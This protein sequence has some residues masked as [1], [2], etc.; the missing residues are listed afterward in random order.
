MAGTN[1]GG[2]MKD[3]VI[4]LGS[5]GDFVKEGMSV[6][7]GGFMGVGNP[8][9]IIDELIRLNIRNLTIICNDTAFVDVGLGKLIV[10]KQAKK[11]IASHIGTNKETGNQMTS[12]ET[13]VVLIPQGTLAEQIRAGGN[14]TGGILT[15]V[16]L[17][18]IV[19]EGKRKI[20]VNGKEYLLELPIRADVALLYG[21]I[22]DHK[23]NIQY[24]ASAQNFNTVMATA[25]DCV[26]VE[27]GK[28]VETGSIDP[29]YVDTPHVFI[30]HI[31][32]GGK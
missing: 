4:P 25:A 3:K 2:R 12:G 5:I 7:V 8:H 10:N 1:N 31:I 29:N 30:D 13:E 11:I 21:E 20:E 9:K 28:L 23:G 19:E 6:M 27:A 22:V 14:G 24:Y 26:I 15:P 32:D 18:T 16:G 17:G